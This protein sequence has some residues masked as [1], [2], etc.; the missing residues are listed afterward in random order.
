MI[1]SIAA[2]SPGL[3]PPFA[4]ATVSATPRTSCLYAGA[5]S[6]AFAASVASAERSAVTVSVSTSCCE[7]VNPNPL[8]WTCATSRTSSLAF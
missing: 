7:A 6:G 3:T 4:S 1:F 5:S 2:V 8:P